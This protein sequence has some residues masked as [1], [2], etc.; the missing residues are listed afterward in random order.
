MT[1]ALVGVDVGGTT[2]EAIVV[3]GNGLAGRS[4]CLTSHAG[5]DRVVADIARLVET[6]LSDAGRSLDD[7][8]AVGI[9]L[10]GQ[11]D[12][13]TGWVRHA[14]NLG[15]G[16]NGY[17]FASALGEILGDPP[18]AVENDVPRSDLGRLRAFRR[19]ETRAA[20][21]RL[22]EH[23]HRDLSRAGRRRQ[24]APRSR[25]NGGRDRSCRSRAGRSRMPLRA[26]GLPRGCGC[27][28]GYRSAVARQQPSDEPLPGSRRWRSGGQSDRRPNQQ[29][30]RQH[31]AVAGD[32]VR[33]RGS[34]AWRRRRFRRG[35]LPR[36][37]PG[38]PLRAR[39]PVGTGC[40]SVASG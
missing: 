26:P 15:V 18:L 14:V 25:R 13:E 35:P 36:V 21:P 40:S 34:R 6:T 22:P 7:M 8:T 39:C 31:R 24:A 33:C 28:A 27:R 17:P 1:P 9:G 19:H 12:P 29:D 2:I 20:E 5:F 3:N 11:V 23:R 30:S 10:P 4:Q 16:A 38:A 37:N 32:G